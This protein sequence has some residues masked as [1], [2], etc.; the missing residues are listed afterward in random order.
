MVS[1]TGKTGKSPLIQPISNLFF[2]YRQYKEARMSF[3]QALKIDENNQNVLRDLANVQLRL[4]DFPGHAESRRKQM[5]ASPQNLQAWNGYLIG[6]YFTKDFG[7]A[8]QV[9]DSIL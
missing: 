7:L 2:A 9:L 5:I 8:H 4:Q 6:A 3:A 1:S